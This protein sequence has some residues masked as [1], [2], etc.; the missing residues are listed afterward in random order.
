MSQMPLP[1]REYMKSTGLFPSGKGARCGLKSFESEGRASFVLFALDQVCADNVTLGGAAHQVERVAGDQGQIGLIVGNDDTAV[2]LID[3]ECFTNLVSMG[4]M[5]HLHVNFVTCFQFP[6]SPKGSFSMACE[7]RVARFTGKDRPVSD[8]LTH[9]LGQFLSFCSID[10]GQNS[11]DAGDEELSDL[12]PSTGFEIGVV[13]LLFG[14]LFV[15]LIP[16]VG[17]GHRQFGILNRNADLIPPLVSVVGYEEKAGNNQN[18]GYA[19][20]Q[21][22]IPPRIVT[23][24]QPNY[25][26]TQGC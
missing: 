22:D 20:G 1:L 24:N 5:I 9:S 13:P 10:D 14:R 26:R 18:D 25:T 4:V 17:D 6:C 16:I 15:Q 21:V 19:S 11:A 8:I 12:I 7:N 2:M 3:D 23:S